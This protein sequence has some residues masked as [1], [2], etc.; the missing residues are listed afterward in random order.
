MTAAFLE[1]IVQKTRSDIAANKCASDVDGVRDRAASRRRTDRGHRFKTAL[2][3]KGKI[4]IIAEI[5]RASPSKGVINNSIDI[6]QLARDYKAG[7]AAAISVLTERQYFHGSLDDLRMVRAAV[8]LPIL[9][10]DF[11][12]DEYQV[13]EAADAGA[14]AVLLIV[15]ALGEQDL[16]SLCRVAEGLKMDALVEVHTAVEMKIAVEIGADII[17]VNSRDLHSLEVSLDVSRQLIREPSGGAV[18]VAESGLNTEAQIRELRDL[19]FDGFLIG[20]AL[21]RSEDPAGALRKLRE[22]ARL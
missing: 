17:G 22:G 1:Q 5:K 18:L 19:G 6:E 2:E 21:M 3:E 12:V 4:N 9:R 7:G 20:E 16:R 13:Y 10:K 15:A 14:D 11:I 8:D